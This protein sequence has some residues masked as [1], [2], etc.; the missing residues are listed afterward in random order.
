MPLAAVTGA[1]GVEVWIAGYGTDRP[2]GR[3]PLRHGLLEISLDRI[4]YQFHDV[5]GEAPF[6][7]HSLPQ[8]GFFVSTSRGVQFPAQPERPERREHMQEGMP[9]EFEGTRMTYFRPDPQEGWHE[10]VMDSE[11]TVA[12]A[13]FPAPRNECN[14]DSCCGVLVDGKDVV[15]PYLRISLNANEEGLQFAHWR[16]A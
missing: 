3:E 10:M 6:L 5:A 7:M 11:G 2:G 1:S 15:L 9:V 13:Y 12:R 16:F 8:G 4:T 14:E